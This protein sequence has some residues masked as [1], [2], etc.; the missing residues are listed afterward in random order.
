[1]DTQEQKCVIVLDE[2]LPVG[3][4]A[5]TAA[6][7]GITLGKQLPACVGPDVPDA[8]GKQHA[9]IISMPVPILKADRKTLRCLRET[10]YSPAFVDLL[11]VDFSD[12]AQS[13]NEYEDYIRK[14]GVTHEEAHNYLGI[15]LCGNKKKVSRLTGSMPLLR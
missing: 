10:L 2:A 13:C 4:L 6:I 1:M 12:V 8:S 15:A 3:I 11:A 14:A 9:G 7:L 5:N